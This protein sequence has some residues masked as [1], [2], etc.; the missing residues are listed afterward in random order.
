[1]SDLNHVIAI[2]SPGEVRVNFGL[3][4]G[5]SATPAEIDQLARLLLEE[6]PEVTIVSEER[7]ELSRHSEALIHQVRIEL[8]EGA[9]ADRVVDVAGRWASECI[10]ERH[11][12]V[13]EL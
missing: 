11:Q 13:A 9:D 12:E 4:A 3:F 8:A 7:Y 2:A 6:F 10:A 1:M 5:R